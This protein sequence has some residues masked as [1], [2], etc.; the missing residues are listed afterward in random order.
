MPAK[1]GHFIHIVDGKDY[2]A[3]TIM[4]AITL[5]RGRGDQ[6]GFIGLDTMINAETLLIKVSVLPAVTINRT[7]RGQLY[8]RN[9]SHTTNTVHEASPQVL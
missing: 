2:D 7:E 4:V 1:C 3:F 8:A 5:Y 9:T 6:S